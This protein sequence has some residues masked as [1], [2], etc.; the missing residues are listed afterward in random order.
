MKS[1]IPSEKPYSDQQKPYD[2]AKPT[3][4]VLSAEVQLEDHPEPL[5]K[6]ESERIKEQDSIPSPKD[7]SSQQRE[8]L[9]QKNLVIKGE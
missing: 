8:V 2:E 5:V 4:E 9:R 3:T 7:K 1:S 6:A